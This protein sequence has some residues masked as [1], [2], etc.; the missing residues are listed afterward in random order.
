MTQRRQAIK[1]CSTSIFRRLLK[2]ARE[3]ARVLRHHRPKAPGWKAFA[4]HPIYRVCAEG[5]E[6]RPLIRDLIC[7]ACPCA[8]HG[9]FRGLRTFFSS[10][11]EATPSLPLEAARASR[12]DTGIET[13]YSPSAAALFAVAIVLSWRQRFDP[14]QRLL[15]QTSRRLCGHRTHSQGRCQNLVAIAGFARRE[16]PPLT[17]QAYFLTG[18]NAIDRN[19]SRACSRVTGSQPRC[20]AAGGGHP[21]APSVLAGETLGPLDGLPIC[22]RIISRR[23]DPV[24][25]TAGAFALQD[26]S[27]GRDQPRWL[28]VCAAQGTV[29]LVRPTCRNGPIPLERIPSPAWSSLG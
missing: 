19:A 24:A 3:A 13:L 4:A 11:L 16:R 10:L 29:I 18:S 12:R 7:R 5:A 25:T 15:F 6:L 26:I 17:T 14:S 27:P 28:R 1:F 20:D 23:I 2:N 21:D 22:S 9:G 8:V